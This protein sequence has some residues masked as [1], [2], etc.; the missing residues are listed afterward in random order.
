MRLGDTA[1]D[2]SRRQ[3]GRSIWPIA[4]I[5][6]VSDQPGQFLLADRGKPAFSR[7]IV[8]SSVRRRPPETSITDSCALRP[9]C[10]GSKNGDAHSLGVCSAN[11]V[12]FPL[13]RLRPSRPWPRSFRFLSSGRVTVILR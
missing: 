2:E 7:T 6:T 4:A 13:V 12:A 8:I 11:P 5:F 10:R 3:K 1:L 9:W